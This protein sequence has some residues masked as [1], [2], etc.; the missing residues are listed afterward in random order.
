MVKYENIVLETEF[1]YIL[2]IMYYGYY[3]II[4]IYAI[5]SSYHIFHVVIIDVKIDL[6][7]LNETPNKKN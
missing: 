7:I 4:D 2:I 3:A 6:I 1:S 5:Y